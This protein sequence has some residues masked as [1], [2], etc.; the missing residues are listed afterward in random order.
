[1]GLFFMK[2]TRRTTKRITAEA[3]AR[4]ADRGE[5]ITSF[6]EGN[7]R[8]VHPI[9]RVNVDLTAAMLESIRQSSRRLG[10]PAL[11]RLQ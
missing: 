1:M 11:G 9:Q 2:K 6:F 8:M 3:I 7:G 5:G 4:L 10:R